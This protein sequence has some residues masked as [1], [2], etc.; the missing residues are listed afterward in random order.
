MS[1]IS[2]V[3]PA[4]NWLMQKVRMELLPNIRNFYSSYQ[5]AAYMINWA[6]ETAKNRSS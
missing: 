1:H 6:I 3:N 5:I 2:N 4:Q